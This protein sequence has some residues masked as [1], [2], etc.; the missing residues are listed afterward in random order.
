[1]QWF[2]KIILKYHEVWMFYCDFQ[3]SYLRPN[4][5][6]SFQILNKNVQLFCNFL[7][8]RELGRI[9]FCHSIWILRARAALI[10]AAQEGVVKTL[11]DHCSIE[12]I[13]VPRLIIV[14]VKIH[15]LLPFCVIDSIKLCLHS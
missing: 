15:F 3:C 9:D 7:K 10:T 8:I 6:V 13:L 1:M 4:N 5:F 11:Q 14:R 2:P 12:P